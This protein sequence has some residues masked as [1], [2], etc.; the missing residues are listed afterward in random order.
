MGVMRSRR[1]MFERVF[2][3]LKVNRDFAGF[4]EELKLLTVNL[5][6]NEIMII[7]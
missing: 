5:R 4:V 7:P 1:V 2:I 6:D 3:Y